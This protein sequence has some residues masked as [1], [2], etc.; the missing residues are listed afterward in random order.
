MKGIAPNRAQGTGGFSL[1]LSRSP[2][3]SC[4][5]AHLSH[6]KYFYCYYYYND[7]DD[8]YYC[9]YYYY[10]YYYRVPTTNYLL[11]THLLPTT[12]YLLPTYL[13]TYLPTTYYLP[14][15]LR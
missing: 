4:P 9:Y 3:S 2:L 13:P 5:R 10:Y 15:C 12:S 8:H 6:N 14:T 1:S 11:P 7:D